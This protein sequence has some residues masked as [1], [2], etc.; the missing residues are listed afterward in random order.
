MELEIKLNDTALFYKPIL[1]PLHM[2][3]GGLKNDKE[4]IIIGG[5][6]I[7]VTAEREQ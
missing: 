5:S 4:Y 2:V 6:E 7:K 3:M 1:I